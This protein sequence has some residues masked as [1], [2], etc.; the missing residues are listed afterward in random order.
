MWQGFRDAGFALPWKP[1]NHLERN[2]IMSKTK[3]QPSLKEIMRLAGQLGT[4]LEGIA[5]GAKQYDKRIHGKSAAILSIH[6]T[7]ELIAKTPNATINRDALDEWA[8]QVIKARRDL[9]SWMKEQ[10]K[11]GGK[12]GGE[13]PDD[14][15]DER[16]NIPF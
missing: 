11:T 6:T 8:N 2:E 10:L 3:K 14:D 9:E 4:L 13:Q 7:L 12:R 16:D 5:A 15:D 1:I